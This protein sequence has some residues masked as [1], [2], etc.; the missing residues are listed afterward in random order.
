MSLANEFDISGAVVPFKVTCGIEKCLFRLI[1]T[2]H[3]LR[4][5]QL[6]YRPGERISPKKGHGGVSG[7]RWTGTRVF[8]CLLNV[9]ALLGVGSPPV[10]TNEAA[11]PAGPVVVLGAVPDTVVQSLW[12]HA[13][14]SS[15]SGGWAAADG[16]HSAALPGG[17]VVWMFGDTFLGPVN[18]NRTLPGDAAIVHNSMV[19]ANGHRFR[20]LVRNTPRGPVALVTPPGITRAEAQARN[21]PWYWD[22]AGIAAGGKLR[23]FETEQTSTNQPAPFDIQEVGTSIA[24]FSLPDLRL[25]SVT[26]TYGNRNL[27][28][29][30]DLFRQGPYTYIY[31]VENTPA[32]KY[33]HLARAGNLTGQWQFYTGSGWSENPSKS[34]RLLGDVGSSYGVT[35]VG[36]HYLLVT[37]DSALGPTIYTYTASSPVGPF[38]HCQAVYRAPESGNGFYAYDVAVHPELSR[39]S[40][41]TLSYNVNTFHT[42]DI[43]RNVQN[44]RARFLDLKLLI[45]R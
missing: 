35:P 28:W 7:L 29:G 17:R 15:T 36:D 13:G 33:V 26:P 11:S 5:D 2:K 8:A 27:T 30:V 6:P 4:E 37:T 19:V 40:E 9:L 42:P 21:Q 43:Y 14:D 23:V 20:T 25:E 24:T 3:R 18:K 34:A 22:D 31:G 12:R 45:R 44:Y 10:G 39:P 1:R 16:T 38:T 32:R 41:L